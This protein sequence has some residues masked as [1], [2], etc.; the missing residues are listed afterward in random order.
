MG[1][2]TNLESNA[3]NLL[4][5]KAIIVGFCG[6]IIW[7]SLFLFIHTFSITEVDPF[8]IF[9]IVFGDSKWLSR[10]YAYFI[11]IIAYGILSIIVA[12]IYFF[13]FRKKKG[14]SL[15]A[16]YGAIV[17]GIVYYAVPVLVLNF[18]PFIN[19][20]VQSH[21]SIFCLLILL[22]VFIGYTISYDYISI[23]MESEE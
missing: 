16:L 8:F 18:N 6:G 13:L 9:K 20:E 3:N 1:K 7:S 5:W 10:W 17:F 11:L 15:G 4:F 19:F 21:I 23:Q 12:V 22:G 14:W 2:Q